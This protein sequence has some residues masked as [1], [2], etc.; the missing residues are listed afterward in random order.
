V[1]AEFGSKTWEYSDRRGNTVATN[2]A[3]EIVKVFSPVEGEGI[4]LCDR[5]DRYFAPMKWDK[6]CSW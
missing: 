5:R 1:F 3:G 6:Y 2:E 4:L